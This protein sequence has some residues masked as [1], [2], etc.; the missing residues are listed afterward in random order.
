M[1]R[2]VLPPAPVQTSS[3]VGHDSF[4]ITHAKGSPRKSSVCGREARSLSFGD[5]EAAKQVHEPSYGVDQATLMMA[6]ART[7]PRVVCEGVRREA[8][9]LSYSETQASDHHSPLLSEGDGKDVGAD[10][11]SSP[12]I[13]GVEHG[14]V[15]LAA[16]TL[17]GELALHAAPSLGVEQLAGGA[18]ASPASLDGAPASEPPLSTSEAEVRSYATPSAD[19]RPASDDEETPDI[20]QPTKPASAALPAPEVLRGMPLAR[21]PST[22]RAALGQLA[23]DPI[24]SP[25]ALLGVTALI[26]L[27]ACA[28][29]W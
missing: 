4:M 7:V 10:G 21:P 17:S 14:S 15:R 20:A 16:R 1:V 28:W 26:I 24:N 13:E 5:G 11:E 27:N 9:S 25:A 3:A 19:E 29:P 18:S 12:L 8:R 2:D 23:A 22:A 6:H